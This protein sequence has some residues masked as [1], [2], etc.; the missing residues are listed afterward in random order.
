MAT[1]GLPA[2]FFRYELS[3]ILLRYTISYGEWTEF[4]TNICAIVGGIFTVA[5]IVEAFL[6]NSYSFVAGDKK[7]R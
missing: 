1:M 4:L 6:R 7:S 3:P 5:S 2:I